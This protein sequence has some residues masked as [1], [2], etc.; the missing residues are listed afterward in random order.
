MFPPLA[1]PLATILL[2]ALVAPGEG[3]AEGSSQWVYAGPGGKLAYRAQPK[4]DRIMDFSYAGYEGGGVMIPDVPVK[5]TVQ[6]GGDD[7]ANI[8]KA[9]DEVSRLSLVDGHRGAVLLAAGAF[10]CDRPLSIAADGVV[11]RGSNG[12]ILQLTGSPH[13]AITASGR[14]AVKDDGPPTPITDGYVPAGADSFSVASAAGL[15]VGDV[16]R[17]T[18]PVTDTWVAFMGMNNLVRSGRDEHWVSGVLQAERTVRAV[19]GNRLTVEPPLA[20]NYDAEYLNPPG[21]TVTKVRVSGTISQVGVEGLRI[22]SP[23]QPVEI[24]VPLYQAVKFESVTDSWMQNLEANDT[25]NTLV[26]DSK[27]SR[28]TIRKVEMTHTVATKGAAKPFDLDVGGTQVLVDRCT[29]R[30][31]GLFY[32]ATMGRTQGPNVILHCEFQG[33]GSIQP[34]MRWSTGLLVDG[35]RL[36]T[37]SIDFMNRGIMGSGHGW[38]IG[39]GVAWNCQA[40]TFLIQQPPGSTNWAIGC[41]GAQTSRTMPGGD[42]RTLLPSGIVDSAQHSVAPESLYLAQLRE[43]LGEQAVRNIGY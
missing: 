10:R 31:D 11:L 14:Q 28:I 16:I 36:P 12:T 30:G 24:T 4:G 32:Y 8:Q 37:G 3:R 2:M 19:V 18:R 17:I 13:V 29:G 22:E 23:R 6:P 27:S 35:C 20:D 43:R 33:T 9:I 25:V 7:C 40:K 34:H 1:R 5:A 15:K 38:A 26:V 21:P 41:Q 42:S 39:W